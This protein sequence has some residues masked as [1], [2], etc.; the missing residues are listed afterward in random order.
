M[1][2]VLFTDDEAPVLD[3]LRTRLYRQ[4]GKWNMVF[5][6]SG[7]RALTEFEREPFDVIVTDM[8]MPGMDGAELLER[9]SERWP[10]TIR[11]GLAGNWRPGS[12]HGRRKA[13]TIC[14]CGLGAARG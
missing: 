4:N 14:T 10:Q 8:R 7:T 2:R 3:G 9:V 6:E 12:R 5:V 11:K 1:T 13:S